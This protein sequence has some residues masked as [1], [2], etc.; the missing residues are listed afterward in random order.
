VT[1]DTEYAKLIIETYDKGNKNAINF[2]EFC[3]FMEDLWISAD[4]IQEQKCSIAY[5]KSLEV[6][7]KLFEWLD[8]DGDGKIKAEDMIYG[9]SRIMI[10]DADVKEVLLKY[11][12]IF[13]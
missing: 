7:E 9:I 1:D 8:R 6:F 4:K 11:L 2:V 12:Y 5:R 13:Y 10:R 3:K